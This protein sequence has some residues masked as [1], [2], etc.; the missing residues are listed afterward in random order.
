LNNLQRAE[1]R[2]DSLDKEETAGGECSMKS[3][4]RRFIKNGNRQ[5]WGHARWVAICGICGA[6]GG[7][8]NPFA[9]ALDNSARNLDIITQQKTPEEVLQNFKY[10]YA[11]RDSLLYADLLDSSF[12][13]EYFDPNLGSSGEFVSWTREV[14]LYTTGRLLRAF[15]VIGLV[16]ADS[17]VSY[18]V[19]END[20]ALLY[21]DFNLKLSNFDFSY[22]LIGYAVLSM[23]RHPGD[24]KW[25]II[26][27]RDESQ[28]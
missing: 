7:C 9:P 24:G 8:V 21:R 22:S 23:R 11:F 27:W 1:G 26:H 13:F 16:W 12:V 10:A 6:L 25:R 3:M 19:I 14:D 20:Q 28:L 18:S 2:L 4:S 15:D 17:S 5:S